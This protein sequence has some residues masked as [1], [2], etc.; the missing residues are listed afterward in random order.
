[1]TK[2]LNPNG[3]LVY[4][5]V[6]AHEAENITSGDIADAL[7]LGKKTV[8]GIVTMTFVR[9]TL[10]SE[11]GE[12]TIVPLMERVVADVEVDENGKP[13][14]KKFIKLTDEGRNIEIEE[15]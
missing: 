1:M 10:K 4:D 15:A 7:D 8:D 5:Y 12:K 6:K 9:N 13:K 11:D 14:M 3:K 2:K